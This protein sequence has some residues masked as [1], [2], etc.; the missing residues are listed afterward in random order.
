M[1]LRL[2]YSKY[3]WLEN[4]NHLRE[5]ALKVCRWI[6]EK[7]RCNAYQCLPGRKP[8]PL[9]KVI[10]LPMFC[11]INSSKASP[12]PE[13]IGSSKHIIYGLD[14]STWMLVSSSLHPQTILPW[15][16]PSLR[17]N[18][19]KLSEEHFFQSKALCLLVTES[20]SYFTFLSLIP[21]ETR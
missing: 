2:F 15:V 18:I 9:S 4:E 6:F 14:H 1:G 10:L 5:A 7:L 13:L 11:T 19:S 8:V 3:S 17:L 12:L 21:K 16:L 20:V